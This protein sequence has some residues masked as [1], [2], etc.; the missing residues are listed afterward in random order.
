M[1]C[2]EVVDPTAN[3]P[4]LICIVEPKN[5]NQKNYCL[6]LKES[7]NYPNSV[8][9]E[10]KAFAG[11]TFSITLQIKG[12]S[13]PIQMAFN[14]NN[15]T[16]IGHALQTIYNILDNVGNNQM[17][18]PNTAQSTVPISMPNAIPT[19]STVPNNLTNTVPITVP[20]SDPNAFPVNVNV[21]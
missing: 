11:S 8:K 17:A 15:E 20:N 16:E 9:Y 5:E 18:M 13:H 21:N 1:G 12:Q 19:N 7:F 3:L 6:K 10:I 14:E 2:K 4:T